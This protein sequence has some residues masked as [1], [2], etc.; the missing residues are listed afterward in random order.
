M[1]PKSDGFTS[2]FEIISE[3]SRTYRMDLEKKRIIGHCDG[4]DAVRQAVYKIIFTQRYGWLIYSWNYGIALQDL[5]GK[6]MTMVYSSLQGCIT[7]ALL[8]D[9]RITNVKDF[10]FE[11]TGRNTLHVTFVVESTEGNFESEVEW[12]V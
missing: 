2:D 7:D 4:V 1:I 10:I 6:P 11:K 8:Q 9:D 3:P 5:F 12:N